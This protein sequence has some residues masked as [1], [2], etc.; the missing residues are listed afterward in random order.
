MKAETAAR[1]PEIRYLPDIPRYW[2][3]K[4]PDKVALIEAAG[5]R[6]YAQLHERSSAIANRLLQMGVKPGDAIGYIG[7]NSIEVFEVWFAALKIGCMLAPF[8]WRLAVEELVAIL[9]D[10]RPPVVFA[11][12]EV[13]ATI[14]QVQQRTTT[15][16]EVVAFQPSTAS[17]GGLAS[18]IERYPTTD[19]AVELD[20]GDI[21]LLSYTSGTTGLPKGVMAAHDAFH[22][23]FLC[24][25]LEPALALHDDDILLMSMPNFHLS[26]SW[27]SIAA[28]YHGATLSILPA[29]DADAVVA[30][31]RRD[32]PTI[33]PIVPTAIQLLVSRPDVTREDFSSVRSIIYFGSPIAPPLLQSAIAKFECEFNQCYG[34]TET[35]FDTIFSHDEHLTADAARLA[36]CGR[37][38]P[39][40][41]MKVVDDRGEEVPAGAVGE[42][43]VRTPM[44]MAGYRN[45]PEAT[46]EVLT[47]GW[48]RT[49]DLA[50]CDDEGF[51]YI[52]D[53]MKD[54]IISGGENIYSAEV[55]RA[56]MK[57]PGIAMAAVIG[58]PDPSWGERVTALVVLKPGAQASEE[59]L[60]KHCRTYL[61]GYKVPKTV[62]FETSLPVTPSGKIRKG[63]LRARFRGN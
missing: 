61:A 56:L 5:T 2:S 42:L 26:G 4:R 51:F 28:L 18:W 38:L 29:F 3:Q 12:V 45:R 36:S 33:V 15:K 20:G 34:T 54:M 57:H 32:R 49:G 11:G 59:E 13:A 9:D 27:V 47:D 1:F 50:K 37:P 55:E 41:D 58:V 21:A 23:S 53:R 14:G 46:S 43:L 7:K 30:T 16:F 48:Y 19:P 24:G 10:A 35:W 8:N 22:H 40:V 25:A 52:V 60:Q 44:M 63:L 6:T 39:M 31:L 17:Q 62:L